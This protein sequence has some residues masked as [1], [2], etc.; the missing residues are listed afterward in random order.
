M[1][2]KIGSHGLVNPLRQDGCKQKEFYKD[3]KWNDVVHKVSAK[4]GLDDK[5]RNA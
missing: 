2:K 3:R 4:Q 5:E 1:L